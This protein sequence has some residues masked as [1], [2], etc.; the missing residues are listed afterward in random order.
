MERVFNEKRLSNRDNLILTCFSVYCSLAL[1][2]NSAIGMVDKVKLV[3]DLFRIAIFFVFAVDVAIDVFT[4]KLKINYYLILF[5]VLALLMT[6]GSKHPHMIIYLL[7]ILELR[8]FDFREV[9][10]TALK[11]YFITFVYIIVLAIFKVFPNGSALRITLS[12]KYLYRYQLGFQS[13]TLAPAYFMF[14]VLMFVVLKNVAASWVELGLLLS[15]NVCLY[16]L[17]NTRFDF[18]LV[19]LLLLIVTTCKLLKNK[20][21]VKINKEILKYCLIVLPCL[22]LL[23]NVILIVGYSQNF[24][25][26]NGFSIFFKLNRMVSNRL[27]FTYQT[28]LTQKITFF[29]TD[30]NLTNVL[31]YPQ[32]AN[33]RT[34]LVLDSSYF[35]NLYRY[36]I[37]GLI[38]MITI[39]SLLI[40]KSFEKKHYWI[41]FALIFCA[42]EGVIGPFMMDYN[43]NMFIFYI[44]SILFEDK[45]EIGVF[46]EE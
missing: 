45:R 33:L 26:I 44:S 7:F 15:I 24:I 40:Y 41:C 4:R 23:F 12:G 9:L 20:V 34:D 22:F 37:S 6:I 16:F 2:T 3:I 28:I 38:I 17:T 10:K 36:G 31:F 39:Y 18:V 13:G 46:Y 19:C 5:S 14:M 8:K 30:L 21:N 29:G 25:G 43:Y 35:L 11:S 27:L 1:F 32:S 42:M